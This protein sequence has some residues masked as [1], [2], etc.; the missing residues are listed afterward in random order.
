MADSADNVERQAAE[1]IAMALKNAENSRREA[2]DASD[3][4]FDGPPINGV[5]VA[6]GN[7][8]MSALMS[9][10]HNVD[11]NAGSHDRFKRRDEQPEKEFAKRSEAETVMPLVAPRVPVGKPQEGR[12][13]QQQ[14]ETFQEMLS[15]LRSKNEAMHE[16]QLPSCGYFNPEIP[17]GIVRLR[18]LTARDE[19]ELA[20]SGRKMKRGGEALERIFQACTNNRI[21][22]RK[23]C[24]EDRFYLLIF[25][26]GISFGTDYEVNIRCPHCNHVNSDKID[27]NRDLFVMSLSQAAES[28]DDAQADRARQLIANGVVRDTFPSS[29]IQFE[30]GLIT[31]EMEIER[32]IRS[33]QVKSVTGNDTALI[34]QYTGFVRT[35]IMKGME[36]TDPKM[37]QA[38]I[39]E[40]PMADTS[41]LREVISSY[42]F[43]VDQ[44]FSYDCQK[45]LENFTT[46]LPIDESFFSIS[47]TRKR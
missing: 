47:R 12:A 3:R 38:V 27:L 4:A 16:I 17:N 29:G 22:P 21:N 23:L 2:Q 20:N 8:A 31:G 39:S 15:Q 46:G 45:C 14:A 43:G 1:H 33:K 6:R 40:L 34:D 25:L 7:D 44:S 11:D 5:P 42:T 35:L 41:Y 24:S 13:S 37:K 10:V 19:M 26:R 18:P 9:A 30:W 28:T 36:V 32:E